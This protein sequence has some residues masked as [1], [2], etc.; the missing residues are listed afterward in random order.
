MAGANSDTSNL[1]LSQSSPQYDNMI[2]RKLDCQ[3][4]IA[5]CTKDIDYYEERIKSL[6]DSSG[7]T[8]QAQMEILDAEL[9]ALYAKTNDILKLVEDT[10]T[11]F[12]ENVAFANA[13][14]IIVPSSVE[15]DYSVPNLIIMI[16]AVEVVV[17]ILFALAAA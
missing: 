3:A 7:K 14:S 1:T 2:N 8:S 12:Y 16:A 4:E 11:E 5:E 13:Y 15:S 10:A 6:N 17:F 9:D